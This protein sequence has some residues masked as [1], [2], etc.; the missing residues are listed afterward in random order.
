MSEIDKKYMDE[1]DKVFKEINE[2]KQKI[3]S[4]F[5]KLIVK[6]YKLD[7]FICYKLNK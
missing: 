6:M 5:E 4:L 3:D 7:S 2:M 1:R